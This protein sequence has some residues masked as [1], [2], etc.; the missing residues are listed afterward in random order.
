MN[1]I[2]I[3]NYNEWIN[4]FRSKICNVSQWPSIASVEIESL[5]DTDT[6]FDAP[7]RSVEQPLE[8]NAPLTISM[9][10]ELEKVGL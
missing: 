10:E 9:A 1:S 5:T 8:H 7:I 3:Y 2:P 6:Q 4:T